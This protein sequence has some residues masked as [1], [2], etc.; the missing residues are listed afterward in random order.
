MPK[1]LIFVVLLARSIWHPFSISNVLLLVRV[2]FPLQGF[3]LVS[4]R[5]RK[6]GGQCGPVSEKV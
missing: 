3:C 5:S 2:G 1:G 4:I 6:M